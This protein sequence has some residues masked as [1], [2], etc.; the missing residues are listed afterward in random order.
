MVCNS[1]LSSIPSGSSFDSAAFPVAE[2][3]VSSSAHS[4]YTVHKRVEFQSILMQIFLPL[5][6]V[7]SR[8]PAV[9][10]FWHV[11]DTPN[12]HITDGRHVLS[13]LT[14]FATSV[15]GSFGSFSRLYYWAP[16]GISSASF[17]R[18]RPSIGCC[19]GWNVVFCHWVV[20]WGWSHLML[21]NFLGWVIF[22]LLKKFQKSMQVFERI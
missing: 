11:S 15:L 17:V 2:D 21:R 7:Q 14:H 8:Q 18:T 13:G 5:F 19:W 1:P 16:P 20:T 12:D 6:Q 9:K 10:Y 3:P 22:D 4:L